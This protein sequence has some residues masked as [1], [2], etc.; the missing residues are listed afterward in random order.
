MSIG[1]T[2]IN[3]TNSSYH[4]PSFFCPRHAAT[5]SRAHSV[6]LVYSVCFV[7][8]LI[9]DSAPPALHT[10]VC[11]AQGPTAVPAPERPTAGPVSL[12]LVPPRCVKVSDSLESH[13]RP[14]GVAGCLRL[15]RKLVSVYSLVHHPFSPR[16]SNKK[17]RKIWTRKK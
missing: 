16:K 4:H 8:A 13:T 11:F 17:I 9:P 15:D 14:R 7:H 10:R 3:N 5:L 12:H 1:L 2:V 6:R